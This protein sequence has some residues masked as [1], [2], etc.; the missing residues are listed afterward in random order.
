MDYKRGGFLPE[1]LFNFLAFLGWSTGDERE[2]LTR[3]ELI[4]AFSLDQVSPK[5]SVLDEKKLEWMNGLYMAEYSTHS[6][7]S[8]CIPLWKG[9]GWIT[10]NTSANDPYIQLVIE[11]L[12]VRSKRITELVENSFY[13]FVDP[14]SYEEKAAKKNFNLEAA[15]ILEQLHEQLLSLDVFTHDSLESLYREFAEKNS[16]PSG[17]LIHP[18]RLAVSGVSFGPGLFELMAALGKKQV[19]RRIEAA[20]SFI[21]GISKE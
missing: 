2:K 21:K 13:F 18:T 14:S 20:V 3:D 15:Q 19:L 8:E 12:K 1:G 11:M 16:V 9:K 7:A 17:K 6:L 5:A 4:K 10:E